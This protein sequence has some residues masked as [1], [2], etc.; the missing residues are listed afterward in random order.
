M[1]RDWYKPFVGLMWLTLPI[2][3]WQ[4]WHVWDQLPAR[5]AVHFDANFH[6]NGFTSREGAVQLGLGIMATMLVLCSLAALIGGALKPISALPILLISYVVV[7]FCWYGNYSIV[8]FNV[9]AQ[10]NHSALVMQA[11]PSRL[12]LV[13]SRAAWRGAMS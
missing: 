5:M 4:Y 9:N 11:A 8:K 6:P 12:S 3:A 7:G 10:A 13:N 2:S 1:T